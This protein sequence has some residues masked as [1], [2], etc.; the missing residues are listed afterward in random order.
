MQTAREVLITRT[1][2]ANEA[3][4]DQQEAESEKTTANTARDSTLAQLD[5]EK[6]AGKKVRLNE[7]LYFYICLKRCA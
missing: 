2:A 3:Q 4:K 5:K 1:T 6:D 7:L